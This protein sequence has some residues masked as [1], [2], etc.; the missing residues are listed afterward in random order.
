[1]R[2][3]LFGGAFDPVHY[4]H[5]FIAEAARVELQLERVLF[6]PSRIVP[7]RRQTQASQEDRLRMLRSA[8]GSN[9]FFAIDQTDLASEATGYTADLLPKV[10]AQRPEDHL[11]FIVGGDSLLDSPWQ[12]F[13]EVLA[14]LDAFAIAPRAEKRLDRLEPFLETLERGA[15][16]KIIFLDLPSLAASATLVR[17]QI[18][19]ASSI[20]YLVP[21]AVARYIAEHGLY[22]NV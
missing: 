2:V 22:T 10:R 3:G 17:S 4:A 9:P 12:R 14:V 21:D 13:E 8:I 15:R 5:L 16:D 1:V 6:L 11:T 19:R 7:H 18:A 20:R